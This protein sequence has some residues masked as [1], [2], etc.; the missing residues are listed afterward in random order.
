[1]LDHL[2]WIRALPVCEAGKIAS[3]VSALGG[4]S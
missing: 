3:A 4:T 1:V 2:H